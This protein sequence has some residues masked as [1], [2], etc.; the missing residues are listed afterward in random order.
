MVAIELTEGSLI[1]HVEGTDKIW[2]LKSRLEIPLEHVAGARPAGAEERGVYSGVRSP[3]T[4]IPGV[5]K[6]GSFHQQDQWTF[7][8]VHD[9]GKAIVIRTN[10]EKYSRLVVEVADP[11]ASVAAIE[12]ALAAR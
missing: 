3:G 1:V 11:A 6:A 2:A 9:L 7:W 5:V 4:N 8:D 10:D 12:A